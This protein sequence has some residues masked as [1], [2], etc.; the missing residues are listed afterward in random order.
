MISQAVPSQR[1]GVRASLNL[2][3]RCLPAAEDPERSGD[4]VDGAGVGHGSATA[5]ESVARPAGAEVDEPR[6][7]ARGRR[8]FVL[9]ELASLKKLP[10]LATAPTEN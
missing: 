3:G 4:R 6:E 10:Q 9:D 5:A 8:G 7:R 2:V 1:E